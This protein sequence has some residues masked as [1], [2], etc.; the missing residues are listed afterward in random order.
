MDV[1]LLCVPHEANAEGKREIGYAGAGL[2]LLLARNGQMERYKGDALFIGGLHPKLKSSKAKTHR[3]TLLPDTWQVA[4]LFSDGFQD[5]FGGPRN[6]KFLSSRFRETLL[7]LRTLP[8]NQQKIA[9]DK[10]L[11]AWQKEG[12]EEQ[13]DDILVMGLRL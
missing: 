5:Q 4:Y 8:L 13:I 3:I 6:R 1:S 11:D 12:N 2:S 9:L 10:R 7:E